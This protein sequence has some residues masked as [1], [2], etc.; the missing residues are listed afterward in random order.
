[1]CRPA[2]N[3]KI[4]LS[5]RVAGAVVELSEQP[6]TPRPNRAHPLPERYRQQNGSLLDTSRSS[7]DVPVGGRIVVASTTSADAAPPKEVAVSIERIRAARRSLV[8]TNAAKL[9]HAVPRD[10]S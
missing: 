5:T 7:L 9:L 3:R 6:T 8:H 1:M 4:R 2:R 10:D